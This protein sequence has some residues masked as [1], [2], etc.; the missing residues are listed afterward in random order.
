MKTYYRDFCGATA[1]ISIAR[2]GAATL[3]VSAGG[4]R[5]VSKTYSTE[6]GARVA[7]GRTG[8]SWREVKKG[9]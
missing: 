9:A 3:K 5:I 7:M 6:R 8:D 4:K 1:S 2:D